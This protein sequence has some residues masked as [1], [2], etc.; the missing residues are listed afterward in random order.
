MAHP[1]DWF[2]RRLAQPNDRPVAAAA[3]VEDPFAGDG[4]LELSQAPALPARE[5]PKP[6]ERRLH[7]FIERRGP[8]PPPRRPIQ[9]P[10]RITL[11]RSAF[12]VRPD[13]VRAAPA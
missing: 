6:G 8:I 10:N 5:L 12:A 2:R 13:I 4:L 1:K 3:A 7:G 11:D 9:Q